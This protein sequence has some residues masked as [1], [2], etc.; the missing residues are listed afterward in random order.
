[1]LLDEYPS[2]GS[3]EVQISCSLSIQREQINKS[4]NHITQVVGKKLLF[5][6]SIIYPFNASQLFWL[7]LQ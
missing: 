4:F 1:M 5:N 2:S 3:A 6:S 7:S